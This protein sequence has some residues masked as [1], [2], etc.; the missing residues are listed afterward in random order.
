M[1]F[2]RSRV[3]R[4]SEKSLGSAKRSHKSCEVATLE[5][6]ND[7]NRAYRSPS[8]MRAAQRDTMH[9]RYVDGNICLGTHYGG[10]RERERDPR[11]DAPMHQHLSRGEYTRVHARG[12]INADRNRD[13]FSLAKVMSILCRFAFWRTDEPSR[14]EVPFSTTSL[15]STRE[16]ESAGSSADL[17]SCEKYKCNIIVT[18]KMNG[19]KQNEMQKKK[20]FKVTLLSEHPPHNHSTIIFPRI[21]DRC[22]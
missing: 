9:R 5:K 1:R 15:R 4:S 22:H 16:Y 21:T 2:F 20:R 13:N 11:C 8:N 19:A 10:E 18:N 7:G 17:V 12:R 3:T 14:E 6:S